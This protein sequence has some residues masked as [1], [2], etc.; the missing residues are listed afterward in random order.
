MLSIKLFISRKNSAFL[1]LDKK[2]NIFYSYDYEPS[3]TTCTIAW[4]NNNA[5]YKSYI[6][7]AA[8]FVYFIPMIIVCYCYY[9]SINLLKK[10]KSDGEHIDVAAEMRA[11]KVSFLS[12]LS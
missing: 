9:G 8:M 2:L 4:H 3:V 11:I 10:P 7:T 6:L 12:S 1:D 5:S